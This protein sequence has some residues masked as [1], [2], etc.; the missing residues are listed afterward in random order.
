MVRLP[1]EVEAALV[2]PPDAAALA[3]AEWH[4]VRAVGRRDAP[5]QVVTHSAQA[6]RPVRDGLSAL[7]QPPRVVASL[8]F[9]PDTELLPT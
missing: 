2:A 3:A 4:A 9:P 6:L 8:E 5:V 1:E 7:L